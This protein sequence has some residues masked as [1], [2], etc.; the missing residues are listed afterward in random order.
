M[1]LTVGVLIIGSLY[2]RPGKRDRWRRWRLDMDHEW[3]VKAPIQYCRRSQNQTYTMVF[4]SELSEDQFGQAIVVQCQRDVSSSSD[5]VKEAE[6]LWSAEDNEVPSLCCSSPKQFISAK[7]GGCVALLANPHSEIPQNLL[8]DWATHV[9]RHYKAN[10]LR[11]VDGKGIL[12]IRW[13]N[14]S[15]DG[16]S[17]PMDLLLATSN[18]RDLTCPTVQNIADAWNQHPE[19]DYFRNNRKHRIETFQD[20]G[21]DKLLH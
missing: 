8:S 3:F 6:W 12:Q 20:P 17:V 19:V 18:D 4:S 7:W 10:D 11:L 13:P 9:A 21:I 5:L 2:W 14:L 1:P 15:S 16:S